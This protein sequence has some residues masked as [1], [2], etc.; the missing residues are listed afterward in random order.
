MISINYDNF[1]KFVTSLG[2]IFFIIGFVWYLGYAWVIDQQTDKYITTQIELIKLNYSVNERIDSINLILKE[3]AGAT[4]R[5]GYQS[6]N[7]S[8][9]FSIGGFILIFI[10]MLIWRRNEKKT[11]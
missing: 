5:L 6:K 2:I 1:G 11:T 3:K 4:V 10:G 9:I 8:L 7:I